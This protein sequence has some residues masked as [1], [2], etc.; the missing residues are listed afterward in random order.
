L[1]KFDCNPKESTW[2]IAG[3]GDRN[4]IIGTPVVHD[5]AVYIAVGQDPELG[6]GEGC[7]WCI[8]PTRRG[9]VSPELAVREVDGETVPIAHQSPQAVDPARGEKAIPNPNSAAVWHYRHFDANGDGEI[10][11][12]ET[13]H[14]T[15]ATIVIRD[16]LLYVVDLA[17]IM[18][19]VDAATGARRDAGAAKAHYTFD[20]MAQS[21]SSPLVADGRIFVAD[22]DGDITVFEIGEGHSEPVA[23]INMG[24]SLYTTPVAAGD[25]LFISTRDRLF[26]IGYPLAEQ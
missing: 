2:S 24:S 26:A 17:G 10:S 5:G 15:M 8:D 4:Y 14:R 7:L 6:E 9:D 16:G 23:E 22:E 19:C 1:W 13:M 3:D 12:D 11:F 25:T 20:L 21:W 18:H